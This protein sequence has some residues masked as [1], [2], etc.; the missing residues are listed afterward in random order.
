M[1]NYFVYI[2]TN[3]SN[4]TFYIGVTNNLSRKT[5]EH[6]HGKIEGFR[7]KYKL[8]KLVYSEDC[9]KISN[10]LVREKQLKN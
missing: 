3:K 5:F 10:A 6:K 1:K 2:S 9:L 8:H 7:K 4:I